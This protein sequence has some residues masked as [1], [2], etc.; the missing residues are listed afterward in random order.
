VEGELAGEQ[1]EGRDIK[2]EGE[3]VAAA[4]AESSRSARVKRQEGGGRGLR[5]IKR[6]WRGREG[7]R[8]GEE[9]R[10]G[11]EERKEGRAPTKNRGFAFRKWRWMEMGDGCVES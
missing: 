6:R 3:D 8:R 4:S 5:E 1:E 9:R 11:G 10:G 7:G 2:R